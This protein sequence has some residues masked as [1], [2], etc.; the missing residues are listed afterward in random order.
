MTK[1]FCVFGTRPEA[2]KIAPIIKQ[3]K[4]RPDQFSLKVCVT[5][6]HRDLL[7]QVLELFSISVDYDLDI[8]RPSQNLTHITTQ[9]FEKLAPLLKDEQ[10]DWL[11]VQGDT[12]TS[13]AAALFGRG[14]PSIHRRHS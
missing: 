9:S 1:I 5:A 3:L 7:D 6:Q 2:I 11:L 10:P 12:S 4:T 14:Q 13:M 8:M